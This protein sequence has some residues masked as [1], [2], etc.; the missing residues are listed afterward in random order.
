MLLGIACHSHLTL[1]F[2][3]LTF[4]S[5]AYTYKVTR[6]KVLTYLLKCCKRRKGQD[7]DL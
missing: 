7:I 2:H 4:I 3:D 1:P 6:L 5:H